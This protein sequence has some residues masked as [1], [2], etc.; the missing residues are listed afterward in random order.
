MSKKTENRMKNKEGISVKERAVIV[1]DAAPATPKHK[2]MSVG[3]K[4]AV[5]VLILI[6][7]V[8]IA[9]MTVILIFNSLMSKVNSTTPW[10]QEEIVLADR[11]NDMS[12]YE[13]ELYL[14]SDAYEAA[15]QEILANYAEASHDLQGCDDVYNYVFV[16]I[17]TFNAES[18][19]MAT[20]ITVA[21]FNDS[22]KEVKYLTFEEDILVYIPMVAKVGRLRDA[23]EWGGT[24][25]LCRTIQHNFGVKINGYIEINLAG[26]AELIDKT[27]GLSIAVTDANTI[28]T[29]IDNYNE[30][31]GREV[32]HITATSGN[33]TMTGEQS[34]AYFRMGSDQMGTV[35]RTLANAVFK[36]G[37][38][39]MN[40]SFSVLTSSAKTAIVEEDFAIIVKMAAF[41]LKDSNVS[42]VHFGDVEDI[43]HRHFKVTMYKD[44]A[45]IKNAI[46]DTIN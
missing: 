34:L 1:P 24:A 36:S 13:D 19:G 9:L 28:N 18:N 16:G 29:A 41:S 32:P 31:F 7:I 45:A 2:K 39:G 42:S 21:S 37:F 23:Y 4:I 35:L 5:I 20:M 10:D 46:N 40:S 43:F 12:V 38:K 44:Y 25:L 27:G 22:T 14:S 30:K 11:I 8:S 26:A 33:V 3:A 15:V 6:A 17:N